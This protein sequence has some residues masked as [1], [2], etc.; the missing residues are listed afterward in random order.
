MNRGAYNVLPDSLFR[1]MLI[2]ATPDKV[3]YTYAQYAGEGAYLT[4]SVHLLAACISSSKVFQPLT[5][6]LT[7]SEKY[8]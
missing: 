5:P 1:Q 7:A 6:L 4:L 2:T 3:P 8:V